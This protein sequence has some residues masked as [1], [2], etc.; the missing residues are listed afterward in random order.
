M[1]M[2]TRN[3]FL[4]AVAGALALGAAVP[5]TGAAAAKRTPLYVSVLS[6]PAPVIGTDGRRHLAYELLLANDGGGAAEVQ[7]VSIRA[8]GGRELQ[9]LSGAQVAGPLENFG[10]QPTA[11]LGAT[12][13]GRM[14]LD[15]TL[16]RRAR[17]PR[18]LVHRFTVRTVSAGGKSR[19]WSFRAASTP[20]SRRRPVELSPPLR[21]GLY[22]DFNGCCARAPHRGAITALNGRAY[23]SERFAM[24]LIRIDA[25]GAAAVGDL[26]KN[27]S[28]F[29]F[30]Q[31]VLA[32]AD[33]RVVTTL[34]TLPENV[35]LNEPPAIA[36]SEEE[37][38]GNTVVLDLGHG[39]FAAYGHLQTGSV[40][41][42]RGQ[43][44]RRGQ[45][46]ARV[47]NTGPSGAPHLHLQ[48]M[49][50]HDLLASDGLPYVFRRFALA[51]EVANLD[52]FLT[53]AAPAV[54]QRSP[55]NG[56]RRSELPLQ[57]SVVRF[58]G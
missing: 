50:G 14:V 45:V 47:G 58:P 28:F 53:G 32:V 16:P 36:F 21:G 38:A 3:A 39:R 41:V 15:V 33:A 8:R 10:Y 4:A 31:P 29:T 52:E 49:D 13:G 18:A 25:H 26:T 37:I 5:A 7:S 57:S 48:V 54:V 2:T 1:E 27:E 56:L 40:R 23:L 9:R 19:T 35:P 22:L 20:V 44:V 34:D 6:P 51:G 24:D 46:I 30:G 42:K 43:R 55:R 12:E 11:T 17:V